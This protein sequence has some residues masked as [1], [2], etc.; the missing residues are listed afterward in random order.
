MGS[1][2]VLASHDPTERRSIIIIT[3]PGLNCRE[4]TPWPN[5]QFDTILCEARK[6]TRARASQNHE[7]K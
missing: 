4:A 3:V 6:W 7:K 2:L 1:S 5:W